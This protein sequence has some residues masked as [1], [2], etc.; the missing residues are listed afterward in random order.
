MASSEGCGRLRWK[1]TSLSPLTGTSLT[2]SYQSLRGFLRNLSCALPCSR[3]KVHFTSLAVNG[4]PSCHLTPE[5]SLKVSAV[6]D[7]S[8]AQL[9]ARSGTMVARLVCGLC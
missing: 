1:V 2:N 7:L 8:Q 5:R 4:T 3:S 6:F 9:V